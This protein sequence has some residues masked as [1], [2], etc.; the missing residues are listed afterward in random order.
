[1]QHC[2]FIYIYA[3]LLEFQMGSYPLGHIQVV[4]RLQ[5]GDELMLK[6]KPKETGFMGTIFSKFKDPSDVTFVGY[7][8]YAKDIEGMG[9]P[10]TT[11]PDGQDIQQEYGYWQDY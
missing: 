9:E 4:V 7:L 8:L 1:M 10:T 6:I 2:H 3:F 5:Q 11:M